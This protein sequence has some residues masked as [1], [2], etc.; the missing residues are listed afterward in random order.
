[1]DMQRV[2][3]GFVALIVGSVIS[4][5]SVAGEDPAERIR[6]LEAPFKKLDFG[7]SLIKDRATGEFVDAQFE[8]LPKDVMGQMYSYLAFSIQW[9]AHPQRRGWPYQDGVA[10]FHDKG[11]DFDVRV[12]AAY[13]KS[14]HDLIEYTW[15]RFGQNLRIVAGLNAMHLDIDLDEVL[16][17][18]EL[19][20]YGNNLLPR[21][22]GLISKVLRLAG[23]DTS[24]QRFE[25]NLPWPN[26]L[27]DGTVFCSDSEKSIMNLW[28]WHQRIDAYVHD[29][30][31]SILIYKKIAQLMGY[32]DGSKWFDDDFRALIHEKAREQ[33]KV[34]PE[35]PNPGE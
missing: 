12:F 35:Q 27:A 1:V 19:N 31:L 25:I 10:V 20:Q 29:G 8:E 4:Q 34:P 15:K 11:G 6:R 16:R 18:P 3:C 17:N 9:D 2:S 5:A 24:R 21:T 14:Q 23:A 28:Q 30:V 32:R 26:E 7:K 33:G 22:R 13:N